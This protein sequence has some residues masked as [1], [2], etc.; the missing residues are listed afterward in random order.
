MQGRNE[1]L[2]TTTDKLYGFSLKLRLWQ[3]NVAP[4]VFEM[5]PLT[6]T[7]TRV[8]NRD[9]LKKNTGSHLINASAKI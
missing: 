3:T 9:F 4:D 1:T 8:V 5:F 7:A 6:E 2:L